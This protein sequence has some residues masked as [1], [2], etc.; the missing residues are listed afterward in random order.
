MLEVHCPVCGKLATVSTD[1]KVVV[2]GVVLLATFTANHVCLDDHAG[3]GKT[4]AS[5]VMWHGWNPCEPAGRHTCATDAACQA[6]R[7]APAWRG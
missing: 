7:A 3:T 2:Q 1:A 4:C 6:W 5:C